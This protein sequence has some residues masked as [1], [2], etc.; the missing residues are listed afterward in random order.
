VTDAPP[1][2]YARTSDGVDIAYWTYGSGPPLVLMPILIASHVQLDW[3][4]PGRASAFERLAQGATVVRYDPR[5]MG[6]SDREATDFTVETALADLVAV[7]DRLGLDRF[8]IMNQ[9]LTGNTGLAFAARNPDRVSGLIHRIVLLPAEQRDATWRRMALISPLAEQDWELYTEIYG[10]LITGWR[11]EGGMSLGELIRAS[12]TPQSYAAIIPAAIARPEEYLNQITRPVL[13]LH[14]LGDQDEGALARRLA[15]IT[16]NCQVVAIPNFAGFGLAI[17]PAGPYPNEVGLAAVLDF[18][19]APETA[20]V[21]VHVDTGLRTVLFTDLVDHTRMMTRL[22][23]EK[24]RDVLR[25]HE[26]IT[27]QVLKEHGGTE[28]KTM[29]DGFMASFNSVTKGVE[30]AIDLQRAFAQPSEEPVAIR[31]GLNAGE[32]IAEE[33]DLFGATVILAARIAA[34]AGPGEIL[35]SDVIRQLVTGKGFVFKDRG[36]FVL[37]GFEEPVRAFEVSWMP[38]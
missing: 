29:G 4:I 22:G 31:I 34:A 30:C 8:A 18:I 10:R 1:I 36:E 33:G 38:S 14:R 25:E 27:R 15:G 21:E 17:T 23:D 6:M 24:G 19:A 2:Q 20:T 9:Q 37:K 5:G 11:D 16:S 35:V 32:P 12:H 28:V 26:R 7:I 13:L 3:S